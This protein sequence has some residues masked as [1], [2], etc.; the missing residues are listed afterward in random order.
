MNNDCGEKNIDKV[1]LKQYQLAMTNL[2]EDS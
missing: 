2:D 1:S